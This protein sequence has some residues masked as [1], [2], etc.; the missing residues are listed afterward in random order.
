MDETRGGTE[1]NTSVRPATSAGVLRL[2]AVHGPGAG[3][4]LAIPSVLATVGRHPS[5]DL[6]L[7]DPR[8][9]GV[10]LELRRAGDRVHVRDAGS[11]NGTWF[12]PHRI[13]DLELAPGGEVSVGGT[14]LRLDVDDQAH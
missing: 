6:V 11:T 12:G 5:N 9:S 4:A 8:V 13:T 1:V 2:S 10:H 3:R 7:N 14:L